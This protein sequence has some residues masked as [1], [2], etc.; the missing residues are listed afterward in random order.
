MVAFQRSDEIGVV[1]MV[2]RFKAVVQQIREFGQTPSQLFKAPHPPR[3]VRGWSQFQELQTIQEGS[4]VDGSGDGTDA[5]SAHTPE[6]ISTRSRS[7]SH[8][9]S[10]DHASVTDPDQE[11][12]DESPMHAR[13]A[14]RSLDV[15]TWGTVGKRGALP[16]FKRLVVQDL[17]NSVR[18][19]RWV[20]QRSWHSR[21]KATAS[22]VVVDNHA[23]REREKERV[24]TTSAG[25]L[26]LPPRHT[27]YL[28]WGY[29][30]TS[31]RAHSVIASESGSIGE[32]RSSVRDAPGWCRHHNKH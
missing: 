28:S 1:A 20:D 5:H 19:M 12:H 22:I 10:E 24:Y 29:L 23:Q 7:V 32:M 4:S 2:G 17:H 14:T 11:D 13:T 6:P 21:W 18:C 16:M 15:P 9:F 26:L 30:D 3:K 27:T 25:T 31:L 8:T